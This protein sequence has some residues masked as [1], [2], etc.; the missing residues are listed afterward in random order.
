[1]WL[2]SIY[3]ININIKK[4]EA[5]KLAKKYMFNMYMGIQVM[6]NTEAL[7]RLLL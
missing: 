1:M 3:F 4:K 6:K 2:Y 7:F 5:P